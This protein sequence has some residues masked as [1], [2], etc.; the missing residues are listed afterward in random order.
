MEIGALA[1]GHGGIPSLEGHAVRPVRQG[2]FLSSL[3]V[4]PPYATPRYVYS[5]V[6]SSWLRCCSVALCQAELDFMAVVSSN[7]KI[8]FGLVCITSGRR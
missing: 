1:T 2:S 8:A 6:A 5:T 7:L 4:S 3:S